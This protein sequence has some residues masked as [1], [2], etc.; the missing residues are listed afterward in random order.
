MVMCRRLRVIA[1]C[2]GSTLS[3]RITHFDDGSLDAVGI[4]RSAELALISFFFFLAGIVGVFVSTEVAASRE[5]GDSHDHEGTETRTLHVPVLGTA[6]GFSEVGP[7]NRIWSRIMAVALAIADR[8]VY[9]R[10]R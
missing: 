2:A 4:V 8:L 10:P 3:D 9:H 5:G 6:S 7:P 1:R